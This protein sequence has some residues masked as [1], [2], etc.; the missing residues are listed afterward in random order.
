MTR[1]MAYSGLKIS[2]I[3]NFIVN[4][5]INQISEENCRSEINAGNVSEPKGY[6]LFSL[7]KS[8]QECDQGFHIL[9]A[10]KIIILF[11]LVLV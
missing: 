5:S 1:S 9:T 11:C 3:I 8:V 6:F 7:L 2:E 4:T 10:I